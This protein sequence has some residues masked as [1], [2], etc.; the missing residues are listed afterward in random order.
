MLGRTGNL[1]L[2]QRPER[3]AGNFVSDLHPVGHGA[4][5]LQPLYGIVGVGLDLFFEVVKIQAS[6]CDRY[7]LVLRIGPGVG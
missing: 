1:E 6:P 5:V 4:R 3:A 7:L 2:R